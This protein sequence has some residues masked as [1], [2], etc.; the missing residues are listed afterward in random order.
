MVLGVNGEQMLNSSE[1]QEMLILAH[2]HNI[3][4]GAKD[5]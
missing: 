4:K 1:K 3:T 2:H 5:L